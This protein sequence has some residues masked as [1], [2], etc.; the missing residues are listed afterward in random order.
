MSTLYVL[1][2]KDDQL[3]NKYKVGIHTGT[4]SDLSG[5]YITALPDVEIVLFMRVPN[6]KDLED[7]L[8]TELSS[9]R[10]PNIN[11]NASEWYQILLEELFKRVFEFQI[12]FYNTYKPSQVDI[13]LQESIPEKKSNRKLNKDEEKKIKKDAQME[14]I[15]KYVHPHL[16]Q[17]DKHLKEFNNNFGLQ[18]SELTQLHVYI[19]DE[20]NRDKAIGN[21]LVL[22]WEEIVSMFTDYSHKARSDQPCNT[23]T[24]IRNSIHSLQKVATEHPEWF[25]ADFKKIDLK[26]PSYVDLQRFQK[27]STLKYRITKEVWSSLE[28]ISYEKWSS[29]VGF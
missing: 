1:T 7:K 20:K 26:R 28:N 21:N 11:D 24:V 22:I 9:Y 10:I 29:Y 3:K 17:I 25:G 15:K 5:R 16:D 19:A 13:P 27:Y 6:A 12:E 8:K 2:T 14:E 23:V 4:P 18:E